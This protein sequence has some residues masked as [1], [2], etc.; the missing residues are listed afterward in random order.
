MSKLFSVLPL[1]LKLLP[2]F[3]AAWAMHDWSI[4]QQ[5]G[6]FETIQQIIAVLVPGILT[7]GSAGAALFV[8]HK[9]K[10][11]ALA[12]DPPVEA[13]DDET[14]I[15]IEAPG[16]SLR[17]KLDNKSASDPKFRERVVDSVRTALDVRTEVAA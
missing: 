8:D 2:I 7:V 4:I 10:Q 1:I 17:A 3:G 9:E 15:T 16:V 12:T 14:V 13:T 5:Q 11:V 6:G